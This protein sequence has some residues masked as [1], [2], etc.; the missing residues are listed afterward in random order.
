MPEPLHPEYFKLQQHFLPWQLSFIATTLFGIFTIQVVSAGVPLRLVNPAW[1]LT[2]VGAILNSAFLPLLGLGLLHFTASLGNWDQSLARA[3]RW[4]TRLAVPVCLGFLLMIPLQ[5]SALLQI[6]GR[7]DAQ[8]QR[9]L[10]SLESLVASLRQ[11]VSQSGSTE[12]LFSRLQSLSA[13]PPPASYRSLSFP[14]L[15]QRMQDD[16][17]VA[18]G[19]LNQRRAAASRARFSKVVPAGSRNTLLLLAFSLGFAALAQRRRS[20]TPVL[21]ETLHGLRALQRNRLPRRRPG[22]RTS[23]RLLAQYVE[24]LSED[25]H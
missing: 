25:R 6:N 20:Q 4:S 15:R 13:P 21:V 24:E 12:D 22:E 18:E 23:E 17:R 10:G 3:L 11:V 1:Q 7:L 8:Q 19:Q 14:V 5:W 16:L 2:V 9:E